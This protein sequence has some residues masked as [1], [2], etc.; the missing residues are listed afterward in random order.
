M[1]FSAEIMARLG[2][3]TTK[4]QNS[5]AN[6]D[7][8]VRKWSAG[9]TGS[10]GDVSRS[11]EGLRKLF[12]AGGILTA[13]RAF[14][15][16]AIEHAREYRGE[17]DSSIE[18]TKR[19]GDT[20]D[21]LKVTGAQW[22]VSIIGA[23]EKA[24]FGLASLIYGTEAA[25]DAYNK[26]DEAARQALDAERVKKLTDAKT[27][28]AKVNRDIAF[29][30]ADGMGKISI[31]TR[32][33][34]DLRT[35]LR[36]VGEQ[37]VEG[38]KLLGELAQ[39]EAA[40]R[41]LSADILKDE[42]RSAEAKADA[43]QRANVELEKQ[44]AARD[45]L[46]V[47][48][49]AEA[50]AVEAKVAAEAAA[51]VQ[52][53]NAAAKAQGFDKLSSQ[54]EAA[55]KQWIAGGKQ[56]PA[57]VTRQGNMRDALGSDVDTNYLIDGKWHAGRARS[58]SDFEGV[59]LAALQEFI[60]RREADAAGIRE[61]YGKGPGALVDVVSGGFVRSMA[62]AIIEQEIRAAQAQLDRINQFAGKDRDRA[63]REFKGDPLAFDRLYAAAQ[64][65]R[66]ETR[67]QTDLLRDIREGQKRQADTF[68]AGLKALG[69]RR[70]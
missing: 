3:D 33:Q 60:R 12:M 48:I 62:T 55:V 39:S 41:K 59:S 32:E 2:L 63:L 15:Q 35:Q 24:G 51:T 54:E 67:V 52:Q 31:L 43:E 61:G 5:L 14:F 36:E 19:F 56:G 20:L 1:A 28:L 47:K 9:T 7:T 68:S 38:Q 6:A 23:V 22:G 69:D 29:S 42:A 53:A 16:G 34:V 26:M 8:S 11:V 45:A 4:F 18:A 46:V 10:V 17:V 65:Q 27:A 30:E 21:K 66:D 58:A 64:S 50:A 40:I 13:A 37:T 25:A 44:K 70:G 49:K 57:P